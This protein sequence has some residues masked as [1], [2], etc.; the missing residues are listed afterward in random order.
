MGIRDLSIF[1]PDDETILKIYTAVRTAGD[2]DLIVLNDFLE[3]ESKQFESG[4]IKLLMALAESG[5]KINYLST[6]SYDVVGDL[7]DK[8]KID[9]FLSLPIDLNVVILR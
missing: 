8:I 3:K 5:K 7:D 6:E 2:Y 9:K 4:V 1:E